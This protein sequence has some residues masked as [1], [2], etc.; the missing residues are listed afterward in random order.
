MMFVKKNE[1]LFPVSKIFMVRRP[2]TLSSVSAI[3]IC[4]SVLTL[5][6]ESNCESC[7]YNQYQ[8][9]GSNV[10][11]PGEWLWDGNEDCPTVNKLV[12]KEEDQCFCDVD[13]FVCAN[14][15]CEDFENSCDVDNQCGDESDEMFCWCGDGQFTRTNAGCIPDNLQCNSM[16]DCGDFSNEVHCFCDA[17]EVFQ[18]TNRKCPHDN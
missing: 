5:A 18:C 16:N 8:Y 10:C 17:D 3:H 2:G 6:L 11:I 12:A 1:N 14:D 4:I 15:R 13:D 7:S 9:P